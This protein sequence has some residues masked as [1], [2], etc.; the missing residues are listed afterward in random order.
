MQPIFLYT[1]I[2]A[3]C[4]AFIS[5]NALWKERDKKEVL[6]GWNLYALVLP[7]NDRWNAALFAQKK[8]GGPLYKFGKAEGT[9]SIEMEL[10][11]WAFAIISGKKEAHDENAIRIC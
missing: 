6:T 4:P 2:D 3:E 9:K 8:S 1:A 7:S 10:P 5:V 11:K